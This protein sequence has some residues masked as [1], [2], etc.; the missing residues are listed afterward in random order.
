MIDL[1][2]HHA[3]ELII[4][5]VLPKQNSKPSKTYDHISKAF[6]FSLNPTSK[7]FCTEG[8][9]GRHALGMLGHGEN[10]DYT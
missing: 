2:S 1:V 4:S 5:S 10:T 3:V 6:G 7:E 9:Q 8:L